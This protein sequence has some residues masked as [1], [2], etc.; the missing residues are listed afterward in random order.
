MIY[1][2]A[3]G[4]ALGCVAT[5][6]VHRE[7]LGYLRTELKAAHAQIAHAVLVRGDVVVPPRM[8]EPVALEPLDREYRDIVEQWEGADSRATEE[9]K[10]RGYIAE[11]WGKAAI[12]RQYGVTT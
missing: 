1:A 12:L 9:H 2:F 11:G 4:L 7:E 10:I 3:A 8:E 6:F 5:W